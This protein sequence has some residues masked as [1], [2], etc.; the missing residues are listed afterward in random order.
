MN[1]GNREKFLK[2]Y[3][4]LPLGVRQEIILVL[5]NNKPITWDVAFFEIDNDTDLS[6]IILGKLEKLELI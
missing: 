3:A 4:N 2:I 5:D 1:T 6:K